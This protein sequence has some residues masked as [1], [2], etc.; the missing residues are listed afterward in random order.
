VVERS[1]GVGKQWGEP[2]TCATPQ[3]LQA[4]MDEMDRRQRGS[5]PVTPDGRSRRQAHPGLA[6]SGR[7]YA[8]EHEGDIWDLIRV[9]EHLAGF[10]LRRKVDAQGKIS[11]CTTRGGSSAA[12]ARGS[13]CG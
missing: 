4:R 6:H 10:A 13:G 2:R 1:Q 5:Y 11:R 7:A 3:E 12:S 9:A 8:Q